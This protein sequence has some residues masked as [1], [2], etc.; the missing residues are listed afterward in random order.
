[1][2][3]KKNQIVPVR[4]LKLSRSGSRYTVVV[5]YDND[6]SFEVY[7]TASKGLAELVFE[8]LSRQIASGASLLT[9]C[10]PENRRMVELTMDQIDYLMSLVE[11][12]EGRHEAKTEGDY[13]LKRMQEQTSRIL[14]RYIL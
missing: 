7:E 13:H 6:P 10:E 3:S 11:T 9:V 4:R 1:M 5:Y 2:N 8:D 14:G 12:E